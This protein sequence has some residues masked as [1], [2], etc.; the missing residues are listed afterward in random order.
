[1]IARVNGLLEL[2]AVIKF[3]RPWPDFKSGQWVQTNG[4]YGYGCA[5]FRMRVN[6]ETF[7]VLEIKTARARPLAVCSRDPSLKKWHAKLK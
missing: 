2:K 6:K 5:C 1:M 4:G 3:P 7:D